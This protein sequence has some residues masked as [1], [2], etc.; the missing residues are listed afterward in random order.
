MVSGSQY[1]R[2]VL[3]CGA[4]PIVPRLPGVDAPHVVTSHQV[5]SGEK[6]ISGTVA[7]IANDL[8]TRILPYR[9]KILTS[10]A[11][12]AVTDDGVRLL[13]LKTGTE[14]DIRADYVV[15]SL[16]VSPDHE[17]TEAFRAK[18]DHLIVV[19]DSRAAG[20]M[21]HAIHDAYL[22]TVSD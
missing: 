8:M 7:V 9:P 16:D 6:Q 10:C 13:D 2:V 18:C 14:K 4:V 5:I 1:D 21:P 3:A 11:L 17:V 19:G 12:Q 20:R 22:K 15:L